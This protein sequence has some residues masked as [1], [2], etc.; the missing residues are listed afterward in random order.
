M[1]SGPLSASRRGWL[2]TT[3]LAAAAGLVSA[4]LMPRGPIT[5]TE[6]I[7][8]LAMGLGLGVAVEAPSKERIVFEHSG[9]RPRFEESREFAELMRRVLDETR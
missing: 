4:L 9:H 2:I 6:A 3:A 8:S 1:T 5:S 7:G